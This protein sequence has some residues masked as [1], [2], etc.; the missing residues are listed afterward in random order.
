[1]SRARVIQFALVFCGALALPLQAQA[2]YDATIAMCQ[3]SAVR[4]LMDAYV[5]DTIRLEPDANAWMSMNK[6][7]GVTGTGIFRERPRGQWR[8]FRYSCS[9]ELHYSPPKALVEVH[10][11]G[12]PPLR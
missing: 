10:V 5:T 7:A 1:V 12:Q 9:Y 11:E 2:R 3:N 4:R 6:A 8:V